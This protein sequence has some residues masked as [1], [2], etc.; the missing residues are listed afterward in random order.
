MRTPEPLFQS[1]GSQLPEMAASPTPRT[2]RQKTPQSKSPPS[3]KSET[4]IVRAGNANPGHMSRPLA[5]IPL[6]G[7]HY[8]AVTCCVLILLSGARAEPASVTAADSPKPPATNAVPL[9]GENP[10]NLKGRTRVTIETNVPPPETIAATNGPKT[11]KW[12]LAWR[13]WDGLHFELVR[14]TFFGREV[15]QITNLHIL[16]LEETRMAGRIGAKIALDGAVF[17][18]ANEFNDFDSGFEV[19]RARLYARG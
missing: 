8:L 1:H 19:R 13:G 18:G 7:K 14:K 5:A 10:Q 9:P 4:Q 6:L 17:A 11:F 12:D 16:N 3:S 2:D 15:Y